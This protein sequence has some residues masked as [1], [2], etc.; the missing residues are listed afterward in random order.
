EQWL[1]ADGVVVHEPFHAGRP[2][3]VTANDYALGVHNG[4]SG[5]V[6]ETPGGRRVVIDAAGGQRDFAPSRMNTVETMHAMTIHKAQGSQAG[7]V[8]VLLPSDDSR[9]LS[10]ELLYT[11]VTRATRRVRVVGSEAVVRAA[12]GR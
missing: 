2:V 11:A 9:L 10:R 4:D 1:A 3:L 5:V 12:V 8:T 6:V 7:D